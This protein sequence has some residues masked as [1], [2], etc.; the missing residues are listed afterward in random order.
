MDF[1]SYLLFYLDDVNIEDHL[2]TIQSKGVSKEEAKILLSLIRS[3]IEKDYELHK[4]LKMYK[5]AVS[6]ATKRL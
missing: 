4:L 3:E 6:G 2:N 5:S 1:P